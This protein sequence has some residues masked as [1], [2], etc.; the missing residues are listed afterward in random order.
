M[1]P[2]Q[3]FINRL[4]P[5]DSF[6]NSRGESCTVERIAPNGTIDASVRHEGIAYLRIYDGKGQGNPA[7]GDIVTK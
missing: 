2:D 4:E 1:K 6:R 7:S 3:N 5:G